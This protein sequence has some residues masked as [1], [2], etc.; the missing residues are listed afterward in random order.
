MS[1][2]YGN[3]FIVPNRAGNL[4]DWLAQSTRESFKISLENIGLKPEGKLVQ[5][6]YT[7]Q[8]CDNW[9]SH[10]WD[11]NPE[12]FGAHGLPTRLPEQVL[13]GVKEGDEIVLH[14]GGKELRLTAA[15]KSHRYARFGTFEETFKQV[16]S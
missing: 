15:Q 7:S 9:T 8:D 14:F 4:E 12:F 16:T 10:H 3:I 2:I 5:V 11:S 1:T 6:W 13:E